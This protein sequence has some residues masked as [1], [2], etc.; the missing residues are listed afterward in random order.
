MNTGQLVNN[1]FFVGLQEFYILMTNFQSSSPLPY[2]SILKIADM[3][4]FSDVY[5][6]SKQFKVHTGTTPTEYIKNAQF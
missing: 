4:N 6:F 5:F 1:W 2:W 3:C